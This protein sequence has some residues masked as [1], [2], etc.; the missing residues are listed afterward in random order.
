MVYRQR[1]RPRSKPGVKTTDPNG[2]P[3]DCC[4]PFPATDQLPFSSHRFEVIGQSYVVIFD[5]GRML[6][7]GGKC[8]FLE[9]GD[10]FDILERQAFRPQ[11]VLEPMERVI[12]RNW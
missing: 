6:Y 11:T 5:H 1:A 7:S 10:Q 8:Y 4:S 9:P 3:A 12:E 2:R